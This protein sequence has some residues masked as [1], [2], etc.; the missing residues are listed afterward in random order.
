MNHLPLAGVMQLSPGEDQ[1]PRREGRR[2]AAAGCGR[3]ARPG[4]TER[5]ICVEGLTGGVLCP[6][7]PHPE[8]QSSR[9][10]LHRASSYPGCTWLPSSHLLLEGLCQGLLFPYSCR[11]STVGSLLEPGL[12]IPC[13][14]S[15]LAPHCGLRT[16]CLCG[17]GGLTFR[18]QKVLHAPALPE[19]RKPWWVRH[20]PG[21][22][23]T[24]WGTSGMGRCHVA[25]R[26]W[27][28]PQFSP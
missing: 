28:R 2:D 20:L 4:R 22:W 15:A 10:L 6:W 9:S 14:R 26:M 25:S 23:H 11:H 27:E 19:G 3:G 8:G 12:H 7:C 24:R 21:L 5:R 16:F 17:G 1:S 13:D 18:S